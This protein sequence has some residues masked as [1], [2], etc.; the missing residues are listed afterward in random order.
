M[1]PLL[2]C[3]T[4]EE[5]R[6]FLLGCD[7]AESARKLEQ[8]LEECNTCSSLMRTEPAADRMVEA[9]ERVG[10]QGETP[11][12]ARLQTLLTVL[13]K[14]LLP[15]DCTRTWT[16]GTSEPNPTLPNSVVERTKLGRYEI[17]GVLGA[18]GMGVVYRAWDPDLQRLVALKV[19]RSWMRETPGARDHFLAEARAIAAIEHDNIVL[20]HSVE[21]HENQPCIVMPLLKGETFAAYLQNHKGPMPVEQIIHF[22]REVL[23]G[24]AAA[25][26]R[27]VIHRDIKPAN[28]WIEPI[29]GSKFGR[30]K[31]LD[32]GLSAEVGEV[33]QRFGGTPGYMAPEQIRGEAPDARAD[34]FSLGC[35]LYLA[36]T[37]RAPFEGENSTAILV[38]T[39]TREPVPVRELNPTLPRDLITLLDRLL[40]KTPS[41]RPE[42]ARSVLVDLALQ[43]DRLAIRLRKRIRQRWLAG[44]A[45]ATVAGGFGVWFLAKPEPLILAAAES[46]PVAVEIVHD[47]DLKK[48]VFTRNGQEQI[49]ALPGEAKLMLVPGDYQLRSMM[50]YP[51]R[52]IEPSSFTLLPGEP[53]ALKISLVGEVARSGSHDAPVTGVVAIPGEEKGSIIILSAS[54]DRTLNSWPHGS[55][56]P[57]TLARLNSPARAF[58]ATPDGQHVVTAGGNKQ[59]PLELDLQIWN[60]STLKALGEPLEGHT[61]AVSTLAMSP[62]G[63]HIL[64]A[65]QGEVILRSRK[66]QRREELIGHGDAKVTSAAFDI[67]GKRLLTG[68]DS[69]FVILWDVSEKRLLKKIVAQTIGEIG[70]VRAVVFLESGFLT[71]GDDGVIRIWNLE[72]FKPRELPAQPKAVLALA[73]SADGKRFL[74]GGA[75]GS[76][77]LWSVSEGTVLASLA[78]H[79]GAVN[80]V[81]FTPDGRGAVS[82]GADR[83]VRLWR[84]P[85]P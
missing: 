67:T 73:V 18:G 72:T 38:R 6:Q 14:T 66:L 25:H 8:H 46:P 48:L 63:S 52:T 61:R 35:M 69:G 32:F 74:S 11:E 84:L 50:E 4:P 76:V 81:A 36:A 47:A 79:Q 19:I 24:L 30:V 65:S 27:G 80:A 5:L 51:G 44:L 12:P 70:A 20:I 75:D 57:N 1:K 43:E 62:D 71:S 68:D 42:S 82:G 9:M 34:L 56:T 29:E 39:I 58:A 21:T 2:S 59:P 41:A 15:E 13:R 55:K 16:G 60:G 77:K 33:G 40:N 45:A 37:G 10:S 3:P 7:T 83:T 78:G 28:I 23:N 49:V 26:E 85:L 64:S 22:A 17:Q 31:I 53:R 54:L